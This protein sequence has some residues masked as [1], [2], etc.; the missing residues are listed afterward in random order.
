MENNDFN[1]P[2]EK[3]RVITCPFCYTVHQLPESLWNEK[4]LTCYV[5]GNTF[6]NPVV[7]E[8]SYRRLYTALA[9]SELIWGI[10]KLVPWFI[11]IWFVT[12]CCFGSD[13][14]IAAS[15]DGSTIYA[16]YMVDAN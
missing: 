3:F 14:A 11:V 2:D 6:R 13:D 4:E 7:E 16:H 9:G 15:R 5:C 10:L 1:L 12:K 8:K